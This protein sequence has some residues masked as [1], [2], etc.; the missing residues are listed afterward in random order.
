[1]A[2][3]T[4]QAHAAGALTVWDLAH[5]AGAVP[6][7]LHAARGRLRGRLRLQVP[8]RRPGRAGLRLGAP[9]PRRAL[10]AA[11]V[12]LDGACGAVR[13]HAATTGRRRASRAT[14]AARRRCCRW[15]RSSAASTR[16]WRPQPLGGMAALRREVGG[17]DRPVRASWS[18][19][20]APGMGL[21]GRLAA[22]RGAARQP[23]LPGARATASGGYAIVQALIARGVIGDF[24]AGDAQASTRPGH[25]ALRLHAAVHPLR[26][27]LG[28]GRAAAPGAGTAAS[29]ARRDSTS[30]PQ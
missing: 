17:A 20:A 2:A 14:C 22:R 10:L 21:G 12:G 27:C 1:M 13:V 18:T 4:A 6:V 28:R 7:D 15:P 3:L 25:P 30:G 26:R 29:G 5:S 9:A 19:S 11:A 16:C 24:R 8:E 23:G